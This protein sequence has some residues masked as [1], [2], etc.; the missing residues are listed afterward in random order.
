M[1]KKL[2]ACLLILT[3]LFAMAPT[4]LAADDT[5]PVGADVFDGERI[6]TTS[7]RTGLAMT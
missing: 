3:M 1:K 7:V 4:A 6:A 2:P 5:A